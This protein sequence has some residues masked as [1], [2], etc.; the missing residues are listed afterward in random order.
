M[1]FAVA[2]RELT[3]DEWRLYRDLRLRA[4]ADAPDAF[5]A[6]LD[7]T[8]A[9][10]DADWEERLRAGAASS[11]DLPLVAE[12]ATP[13]RAPAPVGLSWGRI[14]ASDLQTA[15]LY[16]MWVAPEARGRGAGRRLLEEVV[17]W[18][19]RTGADLLELGV[20]CGNSAASRLYAEH[21]FCPVG[22]PEPLRPGSALFAQPM[23]LRLEPI[24]LRLDDLR[25][26]AVIALL[27]E[28]L[29]S[30]AEHSPPESVHAL[31]FDALRARDVTFW[32]AW[33]GS[34]LLGCGALRELSSTHGEVK[35]MRTASAH[36]RKGVASRLVDRM[37]RVAK[38]RGYR[39]LSLETG[40][41]DAFLPA[42]TLYARFGF[43][44][45][46]PFGSYVDDPFSVFMS[47]ELEG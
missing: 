17:A 33:E 4:L 8:N 9:R 42:R 13:N 47:L 11:L 37:I 25:T 16:Q 45:C 23:E 20:T 43:E 2:I 35:S 5:G 15:A 41:A 12:L 7:E 30:V 21:G 10:T 6:T 22:E 34:E 44:P 32:S 3:A 26:P 36:L 46:G 29:V 24:E 39:R 40:A 19:R 1:P 28:H 14:E 18:A 38:S 27:E 31:D